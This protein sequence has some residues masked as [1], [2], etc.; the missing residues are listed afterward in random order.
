VN[1]RQT[2][3]KL[4][5]GCELGE[6]EKYKMMLERV[7]RDTETDKIKTTEEAIRRLVDELTRSNVLKEYF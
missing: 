7:I 4:K 1:S 6:Q 2:K 3:N 5:A